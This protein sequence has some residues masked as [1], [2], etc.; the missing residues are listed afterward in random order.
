MDLAFHPDSRTALVGI[1]GDGT[2][3]VLDLEQATVRCPILRVMASRVSHSSRAGLHSR[4]NTMGRTLT[5]S[6]SCVWKVHV[7]KLLLG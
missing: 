7:S 1:Q 2:I 4:S 3:S 6:P 5:R